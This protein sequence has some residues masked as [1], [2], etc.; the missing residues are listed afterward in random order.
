M[1]IASS[2]FPRPTSFY[3]AANEQ[4]NHTAITRDPTFQSALAAAITSIFV[5]RNSGLNFNP[6][7]SQQST[8]T[9]N[10]SIGCATSFLN[11]FPQSVISQHKV[12]FAPLTLSTSKSQAIPFEDEDKEIKLL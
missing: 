1:N 9:S 3:K 6:N 8:S 12:D 5:G 4:K 2:P 11:K 7:F 10:G